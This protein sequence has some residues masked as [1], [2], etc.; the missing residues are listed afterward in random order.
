MH[1]AE[2]IMLRINTCIQGSHS[3]P[4]LFF[5]FQGYIWEVMWYHCVIMNYNTANYPALLMFSSSSASGNMLCV[6]YLQIKILW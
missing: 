4:G 1:F 5:S 6:R 2:F 3:F